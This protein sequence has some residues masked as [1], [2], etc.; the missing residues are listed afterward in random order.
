MKSTK[1]TLFTALF[2]FTLMF[3]SCSHRLVDFT[4]ISSKNHGLKFDKSKGIRV[5]GESFGFLGIGANIKD[6]MDNALQSAGPQ[7]DLLIDGVVKIEDYTL[8][9]GYVVEGTAISST[10]LKAELGTKGFEDWC[11]ANAIFDATTANN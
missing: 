11:K 4:V 9:A 8:V 5:K 6:A 7:Y 3:S 10:D 1:L 2:A